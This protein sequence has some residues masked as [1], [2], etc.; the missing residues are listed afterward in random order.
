VF[1]VTPGAISHN[2]VF[3]DAEVFAAFESPAVLDP[4]NAS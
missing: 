3:Q 4:S 1:T 2:V